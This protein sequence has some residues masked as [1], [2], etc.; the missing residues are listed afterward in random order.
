MRDIDFNEWKTPTGFPDW[1]LVSKD[2]G[3]LLLD[4]FVKQGSADRLVKSK[5]L[6]S[7]DDGRGYRVVQFRVDGKNKGYRIHRLVMKA[8][9]GECGDGL[10]VNHKNGVRSD[11]RFENLEWCTRSENLKHSYDVLGRVAAFSGK[12]AHNKGVTNSPASS[13]PIIGTPV[14]GGE[15]VSFPSIK[16]AGRKGFSRDGIAHCLIGGQKTSRGY[17]WRYA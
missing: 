10:D 3:V 6:S 15:C 14:G 8:H 9:S 16:E 13:K 17:T 7:K 1:V 11:N 5:I 2:G 4:R 12:V